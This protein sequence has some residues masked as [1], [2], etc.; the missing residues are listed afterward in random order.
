LICRIPD[1]KFSNNP[2]EIWLSRRKAVGSQPSTNA[3]VI[4]G[5][6][7]SGEEG[8]CFMNLNVETDGMPFHT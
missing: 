5:L 7:D 1:G 6:G 2:S 4:G 8:R 3:S